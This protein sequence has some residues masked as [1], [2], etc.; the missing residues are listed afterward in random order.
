MSSKMHYRSVKENDDYILV[1]VKF[2]IASM[3]LKEDME[4]DVY[5]EF[6]S[7]YY[8]LFLFEREN[9]SGYIKEPIALRKD[10]LVGE[11]ILSHPEIWS[12]DDINIT[13]DKV[14]NAYLIASHSQNLKMANKIEPLFIRRIYGSRDELGN[15][16]SLTVLDYIVDNG[17]FKE[18][19]KELD[20][21]VDNG[22]KEYIVYEDGEYFKK[23]LVP[24]KEK[25]K[26]KSS[27]N[28]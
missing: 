7:I 8:K 3:T 19:L 26:V 24:E 17:D 21:K 12:N 5:S 28:S 27:A 15:I 9:D 22:V 10:G 16:C 18:Y 1:D 2:D 20:G 23:V 14:V 11:Y 25:M 13:Y 6:Q 4:K